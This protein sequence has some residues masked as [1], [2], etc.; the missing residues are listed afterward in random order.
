M[1]GPVVRPDDPLLADEAARLSSAYVHVPFCARRCP[2]CDFAVVVDGDPGA[3]AGTDAYVEA[4]VSE[5][6]ME[7]PWVP[8]DAIAFGGGTPSRLPAASLGRIIGALRDRFG[9]VDGAEVAIEV[10]PEDWTDR[11][12]DELLAVGFDRVSFG[13]QSFDPRTLASLGRRHG[14]GQAE[15]AVVS[16]RRAGFRSVGIDLIYGTPGEG[17][18]R[19]VATVRRALALDVDH[20]SAY[21]L[22]VERG[23]ELSRSIL[24][25]APAPDPDHQAD[26]YEAVS[27]LAAAAGLVR[28]E[29]SNW[30]RPGHH[31]RYNL[32]TW[33]GGEFVAFGTGAHD[34]RDGVRARNVRRL[35]VYLDRVAS[36]LR[37]RAGAERLEG[38]AADVERLV[39]GLRRVAGVR[40][41]ELVDRLVAGPAGR[42]LVAAGV[43]RVGADR[44]VVER[45]LLTDEVSR[46]A[47]ALV[48]RDLS[49]SDGDC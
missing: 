28:Y 37:P 27:E 20:L 16:A 31:S 5:I 47:L 34:H 14:P 6:A 13:V 48:G 18:D 3:D 10:N 36:G 40:R 49:V 1:T 39:L 33:G 2:Y 11:Y 29:V 7:R 24:A 23:T 15:A 42:R 35:D 45:P 8:L 26:A 9:V 17:L 21:A 19:W 38:E 32:A 30:A 22:T 4:V 41:D 44:L 12:A 46:A 43:L 25:G